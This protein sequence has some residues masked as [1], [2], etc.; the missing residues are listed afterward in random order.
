MS[1]EQTGFAAEKRPDND[2][3]K[4]IT[5][6]PESRVV[7]AQPKEETLRQRWNAVQ[8]SKTTVFWFCL[9]SVLLTMLVGFTWGGWVRGSVAERTAAT[10][11]QNA[12]VQRL[13]TIC[14][15]QFNLDPDKAQKLV[16]LQAKSAYQRGEYVTSQ[17]WAMVPGD[18]KP[19]AKVADTC[20][21]ELML[22]KP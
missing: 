20:A 10:T 11:A 19:A 9:A 2:N 14:V 6:P 7:Q 8:P 12:V 4:R 22:I 3:R 13:A 5:S 21:K 15:A 18:E 16:E 17:G 1:Q